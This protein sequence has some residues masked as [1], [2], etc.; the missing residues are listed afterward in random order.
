MKNKFLIGL[1]IILCLVLMATPVMAAGGSA[2]VSSAAG[3]PGSTAYLTVSISGFEHA[4]SISVAVSG[5]TLDT[6]NSSWL[7]ADGVLSSFSGNAG[8]WAADDARSLNGNVATL[9]FTVPAPEVGQTDLDYEVSV[10]VRVKNDTETLGTVSAA[11]KVT[12]ENP[13]TNITL[14]PGSV[15]LTLGSNETADL[16]AT[17]TPENTTD[18]VVWSS[19]N[20][21]VATV[22][23]GKVTAHKTGTA[24]ITA[25]VGSMSQTCKVTVICS[26]LN[27]TETPAKNATCTATG[28]NQ[29]WTCDEC[30]VVFAADKTTVTSV[31]EQTLPKADH[32]MGE[33][34][35]SVKPT[36]TTVGE[37]K[38]SCQNK[39]CEYVETDEIP[40]LWEVAFANMS[41]SNSLGMNFAFAQGNEADWTGYYAKIT[42]N[43]ADGRADAVVTI[44]AAQW[45]KATIKGVPHFTIS[46]TGIA[47][48]EMGDSIYVCIYNADGE[49]VSGVWMDSAL[50]YALRAYNAEGA[51]EK[52]KRMLIDMLNY[53][54]AAQQLFGYNTENL[55]NA[56]LTAEQKAMA[57]QQVETASSLVRG[58]N[59]LG[60][61]LTLE[62]EI[63]IN[64]AFR[65]VTQGMYAEVSFTNHKGRVIKEAARMDI[66]GS[67]GIVRVDQIAVADGRTLVT[68]TVYNADGSVYGT[69]TDSLE[70]YIARVSGNEPENAALYEKIMMF[71][72]SSYN[73]LH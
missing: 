19:N 55:A 39:D 31:A 10:T 6:V 21:S 53:G 59:Y 25:T 24:T 13:A 43:Y 33:W 1:S 7:L 14:T 49:A 32:T 23:G 52:E 66:E 61:N 18:K 12:V 11:G 56:T 57:T 38:R 58:N 45:G 8:V 26:H 54:A 50:K 27:L 28:N 60:T 34:E 37:K 20:E 35:V 17:V 71:S 51:K 16:T 15:T 69:A 42:K 62:N 30:G 63:R 36:T 41:L 73:F 67:I 46:F 22:S 44:P 2:A 29:Y 48:K 70:G 65:G 9:A 64:M 4:D 5:L 3:K 40:V 72:D 68:V 47:A